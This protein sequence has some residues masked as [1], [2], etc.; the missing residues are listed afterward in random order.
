MYDDL[1]LSEHLN[2]L[3]MTFLDRRM[4]VFKGLQEHLFL[5]FVSVGLA[6]L[7]SV[8]LAIFLTRKQKYAESIIGVAALFQT[9]PS[10]ALLGFFIPFLGI[11][12]KPAIVALVM[13][14]LLPILRNTYTGIV[15]VDPTLKEVGKG[16][17]MTDFQILTQIELPLSISFIM[18]GIRMSTVWT[19]GIT[20]IAAF[21]GAGGLGDIIFRGISMNNNY[22][23][24][25][26]SFAAAMLAIFFDLILKAFEK[27]L[28][29]KGL[30]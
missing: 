6:I 5:V 22:I 29:P 18:A 14:A 2:I 1:T 19:V 7:I 4:D 26:G 21:I 24:F 23:T 30:K 15:E 13:Y 28:T 8:P 9:I 27:K 17:G 11:G 10:L 16:L 12:R 3:W 25:I 20:T